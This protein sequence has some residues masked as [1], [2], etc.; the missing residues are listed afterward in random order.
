MVWA[1]HPL[2]LVATVT[3]R[4][5]GAPICMR[6]ILHVC[7]RFGAGAFGGSGLFRLGRG[8]GE[9]LVVGHLHVRNF[10]FTIDLGLFLRGG[11]G[12]G[13]S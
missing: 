9:R 4:S 7:E 13:R 3:S 11:L 2:V 8:V 12:L 5:T 6:L 10:I 1:T